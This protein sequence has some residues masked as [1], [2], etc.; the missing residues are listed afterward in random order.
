[1]NY[2]GENFEEFIKK[3]KQDQTFAQKYGDLGPIYGKQ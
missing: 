3:I 1:M 2:Q